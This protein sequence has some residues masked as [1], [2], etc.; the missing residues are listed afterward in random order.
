MDSNMA[1]T[2]NKMKMFFKV[3]LIGSLNTGLS[4]MARLR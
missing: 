1:K 2:P 4:P 3:V